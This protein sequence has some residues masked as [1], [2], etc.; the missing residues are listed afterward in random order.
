MGAHAHGTHKLAK[1]ME[2]DNTMGLSRCRED[3]E[4]GSYYSVGINF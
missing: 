2:S 3:R 1:V 4:I